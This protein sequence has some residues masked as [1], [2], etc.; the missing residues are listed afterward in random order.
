LEEAMKILPVLLL[1]LGSCC[2]T[3]EPCITPPPMQSDRDNEIGLGISVQLAQVPVGGS[4]SANFKNILNTKYDLL[5]ENDK[6]LYLFLKAIDCYLKDGKVG[7]AI[8]TD[9]AAA[10]RAK[11]LVKAGTAPP[12][13][14]TVPLAKSTVGPAANSL[15]VRFHVGPLP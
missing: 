9:M 12:T 7:E 13:A 15:L 4:L 6:A 10:V 5:D 8:A 1:V 11:Y 2:S 3:A 14:R